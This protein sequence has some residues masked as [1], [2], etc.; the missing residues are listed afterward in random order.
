MALCSLPG[1]PLTWSGIASVSVLDGERG[2]LSEEMAVWTRPVSQEMVNSS[3]DL[4]EPFVSHL[5]RVAIRQ[6][7]LLA[8]LSNV[9]EKMVCMHSATKVELLRTW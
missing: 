6:P 3:A 4:N 9:A 2:L 7:F 1:M 5:T 8:C